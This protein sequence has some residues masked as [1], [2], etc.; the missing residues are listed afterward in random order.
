MRWFGVAAGTAVP[1]HREP[2][3]AAAAHAAAR[4]RRPGRGPR[5][6]RDRLRDDLAAEE[7]QVRDVRRRRGGRLRAGGRGGA[8]A[9]SRRS[10]RPSRRRDTGSPRSRRRPRAAPRPLRRRRRA[11]RGARP[12]PRT[13]SMTHR[14]NDRRPRRR[15][16]RRGGGRG[17]QVRARRAWAREKSMPPPAALAPARAPGELRRDGEQQH[18]EELPQDVLVQGRRRSGSRR[19][20]PAIEA[21]PSTSELRQRTLP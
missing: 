7:R 2:D 5:A 13:R 17:R 3:E 20:R 8:R 18:R 4:L 11:G 19:R 14:R 6:R 16:P 12:S 9:E 10:R 21:S 1:E 15:R